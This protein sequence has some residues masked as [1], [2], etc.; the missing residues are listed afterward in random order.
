MLM[1]I[2]ELML[3][4]L[5]EILF[6]M[7]RMST[8]LNVAVPV[9]EFLSSESQ[10]NR[11]VLNEFFLI[12]SSYFNSAEPFTESFIRQL[13]KH[14]IHVC[15]C[16]IIAIHES[17]QI[18]SLHGIVGTSCNCWLVL[19]VQAVMAKRFCAIHFKGF[20]NKCAEAI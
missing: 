8:T 12:S 14:P 7:S 15:V 19:K 3:R 5:A 18:R 6:D 4:H 2:L 1:E 17:P 10:T 20:N 11:S 9:L 13:H 16:N